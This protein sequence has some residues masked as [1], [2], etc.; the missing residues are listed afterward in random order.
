MKSIDNIEKSLDERFDEKLFT[1]R[2][3]HIKEF[4]LQKKPK[5]TSSFFHIEFSESIPE[6][7][8]EFL[9]E[10]IPNI[11][12]F[13]SK[14]GLNPVSPGTTFSSGA[15]GTFDRRRHCFRRER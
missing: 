8:K 12:D 2:E 9:K 6:N 1:I 11:L 13:P 5:K 7:T 14:F 10:K 15:R 4:D 3:S